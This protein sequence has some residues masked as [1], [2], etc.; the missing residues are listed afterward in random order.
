MRKNMYDWGNIAISSACGHCPRHTHRTPPIFVRLR[1]DQKRNPTPA[2]RND[3]LSTTNQTPGAKA[4]KRT[5]G[6]KAMLANA[7]LQGTRARTKSDDKQGAK[8]HH[9]PHNSALK[10]KT[11]NPCASATLVAERLLAPNAPHPQARS[12]ASNRAHSSLPN[13]AHHAATANNIH[14]HMAQTGDNC[15]RRIRRIQMADGQSAQCPAEE[16]TEQ[17]HGDGKH[18][19]DPKATNRCRQNPNQF[20]GRRPSSTIFPAPRARAPAP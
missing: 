6:A 8:N 16:H 7:A 4:L 19:S 9:R 10:N 17:T 18:L 14:K 12:P 20:S 15:N 11:H 5:R 13:M 3:A 2:L 1:K